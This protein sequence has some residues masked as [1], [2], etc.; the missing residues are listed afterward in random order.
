MNLSLTENV[1]LPK[2]A[3]L[4]RVVDEIAEVKAFHWHF[5]DPVEQAAF[6][7]FRPASSRRYRSLVSTS[8]WA[9]GRSDESGRRIAQTPKHQPCRYMKAEVRATQPM[10]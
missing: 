10:S 4:D 1:Y 8:R 2:I 6:K 5:D 9:C 3:A 7:N